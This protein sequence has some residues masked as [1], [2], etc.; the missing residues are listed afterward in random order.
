MKLLS[1]KNL[2]MT[3]ALSVAG[4][5]LIGAGAHATFYQSV[6]SAQTVTAGQLHVIL[7]AEGASGD[8]T[9][10]NPLVLPAVGPTQSSFVASNPIT[11]T[12]VGNINATEAS[13]QIGATTDGSTASGVM[14][15]Q[16][17]AC[18]SSG[19]TIVFN[20]PLN[21]AIGYGTITVGAQ[22]LPPNDNYTL[23][24]YAGSTDA[25]CGAQFTAVSG[26]AFQ[27]TPT[28]S[29]VSGATNPSAASL[30]NAAQGGVVTPTFTMTVTG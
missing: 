25:G 3:G 10:G 4:L 18:L 23:T 26:G 14:Q 8:G 16:L 2:A 7:Q 13:I 5:G 27:P 9:T 20:E 30:T 19:T 29:I 6:S 15:S 21:T 24:I 28:Q 12:N 17:W 11:V 1:L 22:V